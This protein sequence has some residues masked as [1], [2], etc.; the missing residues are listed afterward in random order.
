MLSRHLYT[1][2]T[3]KTRVYKPNK[4]ITKMSVIQYHEE[5][6]ESDE[7]INTP[8]PPRLRVA[9]IG[10]TK[11]GKSYAAQ[12]LKQVYQARYTTAVAQCIAYKTSDEFIQHPKLFRSYSS[13]SHYIGYIQ[14]RENEDSDLIVV[15]D[16]MYKTEAQYLREKGY[17]I[18]YLKTPWYVRLARLIQHDENQSHVP[19]T[20]VK[21]M[22]HS[23]ELA[24]EE[25]PQ[26][27]WDHCIVDESEV[28]GL[29]DQL[30]GV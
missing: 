23:S 29:I 8:K 28:K 17:T 27:M 3:R 22:T 18:V 4:H 26:E 6:I 21:W 11:S 2:H 10:Q 13:D 9:F 25:I 5:A 12:T 7:E 14:N 19:K 24:L 30:V 16:L 20:T 1:P 15:D